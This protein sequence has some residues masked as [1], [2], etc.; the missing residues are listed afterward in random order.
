MNRLRDI[1]A[2]LAGLF[3]E[4]PFKKLWLIPLSLSVFLISLITSIYRNFPSELVTGKINENL[5]AFKIRISSEKAEV[6]FPFRIYLFSP[7]IYYRN[8]KRM[9]P[10]QIQIKISLLKQLFGKRNA[11]VKV[12]N[13]DGR[14]EFGF[15]LSGKTFSFRAKAHDFKYGG[16]IEMPL[17]TISYQTF[18]DGKVD[19]VIN[20]EDITLSKMRGEI[21]LKE[22]LIEKL[23]IGNGEFTN[24]SAGDIKI[25]LS[26]DRGVIS[27]GDSSFR[28]KDLEGRLNLE[29][30]LNRKLTL[31]RLKGEISLKLG[32][33][34]REMLGSLNLPLQT[35]LKDG[36]RIDLKVSGTAGNPVFSLL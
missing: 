5:T 22:L 20:T 29:I 4:L 10:E 28:S 26:M 7:V 3:R 9:E 13:G 34:V 15:A 30:V 14:F 23:L 8:E 11:T 25:P 35:F 31:S 18:L 32:F 24:I 33:R 1:S 2:Y 19:G 17:Y 27:T 36:N 6:R 16:R 12:L 21:N